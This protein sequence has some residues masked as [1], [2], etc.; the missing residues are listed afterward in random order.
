[1]SN[2]RP[3]NVMADRNERVLIISW[4]DGKECR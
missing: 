4:N 2:I 3:T 1:M